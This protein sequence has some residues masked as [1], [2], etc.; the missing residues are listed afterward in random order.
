MFWQTWSFAFGV[1]VPN[2]LIL[3]LGMVLRRTAFDKGTAVSF[4]VVATVFLG[5]FL[6][7][8]R[9]VAGYLLRHRAVA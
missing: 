3:L 5:L 4:I 2:L 1:T 6:L 9:L 7:G 8:W